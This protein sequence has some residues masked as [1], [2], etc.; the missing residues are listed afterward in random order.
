[1]P[2]SNN[3]AGYFFDTSITFPNVSGVSKL[4]LDDV[5][6]FT[7]YPIALS[8]LFVGLI[9]GGAARKL[10][11]IAVILSLFI[12]YTLLIQFILFDKNHFNIGGLIGSIITFSMFAWGLY[13]LYI[14]YSKVLIVDNFK[15]TTLERFS[16]ILKKSNNL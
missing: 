4:D 1:M 9:F 2:F 16:L 15:D 8:F 14:Y 10:P 6:F 13:R 11:K 3:I 5:F 7:S 12:Q